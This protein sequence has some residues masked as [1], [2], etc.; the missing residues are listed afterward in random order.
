LFRRK[1][2]PGLI[3]VLV[4]FA[5]HVFLGLWLIFGDLP[6]GRGRKLGGDEGDL[7]NF[8]PPIELNISGSEFHEEEPP[9]KPN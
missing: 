3:I 4:I 6:D 5:V 2:M 8:D 1:A 9:K 7:R